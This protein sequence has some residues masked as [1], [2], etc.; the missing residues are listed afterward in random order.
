[1]IGLNDIL[2][3][4]SI[5]GIIA[6]GMIITKVIKALS[7]DED[8]IHKNIEGLNKDVLNLNKELFKDNERLREENKNI[9]E[10][11]AFYDKQSTKKKTK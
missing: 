1:M 2:A 9:K 7:K 8:I 10:K 4:E 5:A 3:P 6:V 11:L